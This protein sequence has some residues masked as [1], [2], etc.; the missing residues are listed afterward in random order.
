MTIPVSPSTADLQQR[1]LAEQ[2]SPD[3]ERLRS[4]GLAANPAGRLTLRWVDRS[5]QTWSDEDEVPQVSRQTELLPDTSKTLISRNNSPDIPFDRSI[6]PYKG[7]EHG[8]VYCFARP[9]H[10]YL[11]LS[12]GLDFE[13]QIFYKTN[14]VALLRKAFDKPGYHCRPLALGANT[15]AYQPAEKS[16]RITRTILEQMLAYRHPVTLVTKGALILRDLDLLQA[17]AAQNLVQVMVSVTTLDLSLKAR[18]EPR[19]A[20]PARRL[21]VIR[22]LREAGV[23]VG[24]MI[25]PVIPVLTDHELERLVER[26]AGAGAQSINYVLL[27]LPHEVKDLFQDWLGTHFPLQAEHVMSR[28]RD[29]RGGRDNDPEFGSRM[30]GSGP[31]AEFLAQRFRRALAKQGLLDASLPELRTDLFRRPGEGEQMTLF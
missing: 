9:S 1:L 6:N 27:R 22:A 24:A 5:E 21:Q 15:D 11:D 16:L 3:T 8:C 28:L 20:G 12:P 25:A 23:P 10:S 17:L 19:A 14:V 7:C 29:M 30:R 31:F 13:T 26:A 18:L 2:R 4:R